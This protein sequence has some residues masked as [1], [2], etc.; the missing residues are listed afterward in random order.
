MWNETKLT[1]RLGIE[2]PIIQGP[3]GGGL[4]TIDLLATVSNAGGM[5]SYGAHILPPE[6]II[7]L[8]R[9]IRQAT[10]KPF[11]VNLW[12]SDHDE[13]GLG[14][15]E[16][17]FTE[18]LALFKPFYDELGIAYPA[19]SEKYTE[20]YEEQVEAIIE[21][22]PPVFSFVYG[23]PSDDILEACRRKNIKTLGAATT[24]DEAIA[25]DDAGVDIILATGFE[26]GGHRVSFLKEA[27]ESL[28]G[29]LALV[30]QV[31]DRVKA[32]V[33]AAGGISD[34]R[35]VKAALALG[36]SGVQMG[37]AF[38]ACAESGTSDMH[39]D[40]ILSDASKHTVLSRAFTGR[41][42]RF[43]PN[44]LIEQAAHIDAMPL[45]FPIQSFFTSPL[46]KAASERTNRDYASM[47]AG[48]GA[49]ILQHRSAK[50]LVASIVADMKR[51]E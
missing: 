12:V 25:L 43:I 27:E 13:G 46:K 44:H 29:T 26:A 34:A 2:Y 3:F 51:A 28:M 47:Y 11:A 9:D 35:G 22:A 38:L 36:A 20:R 42:A 15:S 39:R 21:A 1:E 37:T 17:Q 7:T 40:A 33:V 5:G 16:A 30:P 48:Q 45:P 19:Y 10:E 32:P 24:L 6:G 18:Y 41:L 49:P 23:I 50:T 14:M 4:S 31:V 8:T